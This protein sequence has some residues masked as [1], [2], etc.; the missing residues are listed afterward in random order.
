MFLKQRDISNLPACGLP[1]LQKGSQPRECVAFNT[2][3][4]AG[5]WLPLTYSNVA[6][7]TQTCRHNY[8]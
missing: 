8:N 2:N 3:N 1:R 5:R 7:A 6:A 4:T